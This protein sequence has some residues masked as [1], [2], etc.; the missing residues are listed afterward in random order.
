MRTDL[1]ESLESDITFNTETE[2]NVI[3]E[4]DIGM[5]EEHDHLERHAGTDFERIEL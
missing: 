2:F 4:L 5:N 3:L 1:T